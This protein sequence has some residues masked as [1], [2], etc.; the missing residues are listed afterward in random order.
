MDS[1][2]KLTTT[3]LASA[4]QLA[5]ERQD[6]L[7]SQNQQRLDLELAL[8]HAE[9]LATAR[10]EALME[11]DSQLKFTASA[12]AHAEELA[13]LREGTIQ[14]QENELENVKRQLNVLHSKPLVR[15]ARRMGLI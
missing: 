7:Q 13:L 15:M 3:A 10:Q 2:L 8:Q 4:E 6:E 1:Q 12:L 11:V 14:V 9:S 5:M